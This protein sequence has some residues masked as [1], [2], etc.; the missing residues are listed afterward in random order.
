MSNVKSV[1]DVLNTT[2]DD[3]P[4]MSA[5]PNDN[6]FIFEVIRYKP[7]QREGVA[8]VEFQARAVED[9][10]GTLDADA[11]KNCFPS[12]ATLFVHTEGGKRMTKAV[13]AKVFNI[14][15]EQGQSLNDVIEDVIGGLFVATTKANDKGYQTLD[16]IRAA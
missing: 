1:E 9:L 15:M 8:G 7:F 13:L 14:K 16:N 10:S 11:L 5:L 4:E 2:F 6:D 12:R 3:L